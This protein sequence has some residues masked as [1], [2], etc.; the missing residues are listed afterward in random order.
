MFCLFIRKTSLNL[1]LLESA[2]DGVS[3]HND[4]FHKLSVLN[5]DQLSLFHF[6]SVITSLA[7]DVMFLVE[8]VC[9]FIC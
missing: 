4:E 5:T 2:S 7:K 8:F 3:Y 9:M 6:T 1:S